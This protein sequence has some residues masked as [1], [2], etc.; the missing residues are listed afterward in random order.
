ME[1][2]FFYCRFIVVFFEKIWNWKA[3]RLVFLSFQ[4]ALPVPAPFSFYSFGYAACHQS[5][6]HYRLI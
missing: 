3:V 5:V 6:V 1:P 2:D 4:A